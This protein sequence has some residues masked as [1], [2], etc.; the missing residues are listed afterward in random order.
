MKQ[1]NVPYLNLMV[2]VLIGGLITIWA[3]VLYYL[4]LLLKNI[5]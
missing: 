3:G 5:S 2:K 4:F 1:T